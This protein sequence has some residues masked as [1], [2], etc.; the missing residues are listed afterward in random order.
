MPDNLI[1]LENKK[2]KTK[3]ILITF[4]I[5]M[6][7][8]VIASAQIDFDSEDLNI[9]DFLDSESSEL[10]PGID[11]NGL[12]NVEILNPNPDLKIN[13]IELIWSNDSYVPPLYQ[14]R[15]LPSIGSKI[16]VDA[17]VVA[18][19]GNPSNLKYSWF[20]DDIFQKNKSGYGKNSFYFYASQRPGNSQTIKIQIFNDDR[21]I[22]E[23]RIIQIPI[24]SP[25][26]AIYPSN[27]NN[28]VADRANEVSVVL[29][30]KEFSFFARP[31]FFSIEKFADFVFEWNFAGQEP[32]ISS[33]YGANVLDLTITNKTENE[34]TGKNLWL[35]VFN[36][37]EK[38]Q[39]ASQIIK[40]KI[41]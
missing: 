4:L 11:L 34:T 27:G 20:I 37:F 31:Y 19:G 14:G 23:E 18:S 29:P 5:L 26:I 28:Y 6:I 10:I 1:K 15:A 35:R 33:D 8:P 41:Y 2:M 25:E 16:L 40:V 17:V 24:V 30:D 22:F 39:E 38:R 7:F 13:N 21:T 12:L 3:S 36:K 32:I 9:D